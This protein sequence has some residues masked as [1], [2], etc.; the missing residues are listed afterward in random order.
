MVAAASE[1]IHRGH[2]LHLA[3]VRSQAIKEIYDRLSL[4]RLIACDSRAIQEKKR[5]Q[6]AGQKVMKRLLHAAISGAFTAWSEMW[7]QNKVCRKIL[8]RILNQLMGSM[9]NSWVYKVANDKE[10]HVKLTRFIKRM[11]HQ[12]Y[13]RYFFAWYENV[14]EVKTTRVKLLRVRTNTRNW[15]RLSCPPIQSYSL[16]AG[17]CACC[18]YSSACRPAC[19]RPRSTLGRF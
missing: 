14:V 8:K 5:L 3:R 11:A 13:G 7:R 2:V 17:L 6:D 1:F 16:T 10:M 18:R 15:P 9:F 19:S 4:L 12:A